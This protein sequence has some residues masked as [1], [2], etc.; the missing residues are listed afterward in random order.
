MSFR[1]LHSY[2]LIVLLTVYLSAI[3]TI[4]HERHFHV[5]PSGDVVYHLHPFSN[6]SKKTP[7]KH[8]HHPGDY[9]DF[10]SNL[11]DFQEAVELCN[12]KK[13]TDPIFNHKIVFRPLHITRIFHPVISLRAPPLVDI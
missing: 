8:T 10:Q 6:D 5:L 7:E 2:F 3:Q 13:A 4:I 12:F 11:L 1:F 9:H